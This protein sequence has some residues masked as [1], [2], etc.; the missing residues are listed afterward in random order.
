M[1]VVRSYATIATLPA[2]RATVPLLI[3]PRC[4]QSGTG[5]QHH[6][7][8]SSFA[9]FALAPPTTTKETHMFEVIVIVGIIIVGLGG[10]WIL[11]MSEIARFNRTND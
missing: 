4:A 6:S 11:G 9:L 5:G 7:A 3:L 2:L 1:V 8:S 10:G